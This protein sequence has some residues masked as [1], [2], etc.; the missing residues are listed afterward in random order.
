MFAN[1]F[2]PGTWCCKERDEVEDCCTNDD[3][4]I[5]TNVGSL[6]LPT[7]T[8]SAPAKTVTVTVTNP[9]QGII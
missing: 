6:L 8:Y 9:S 5:T 1:S 4:I 2:S 7:A 3:A